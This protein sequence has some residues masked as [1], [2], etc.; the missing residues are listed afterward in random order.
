[1][2]WEK[3]CK[4]S[5]ISAGKMRAVSAGGVPIVLLHGERG[6]MAIPP[7]CPHMANPLA[8]GAFDGCV[9]TCTKHLWQWSIPDGE[10]IGEAEMPLLIYQSEVRDGE[11]WVKVETELAYDHEK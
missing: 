8:E 10:P 1:M 6:F 4:A 7:S 5:E 2:A 3:V 9:L 11:I